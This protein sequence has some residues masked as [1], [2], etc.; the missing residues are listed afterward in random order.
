MKNEKIFEKAL[1]KS[2]EIGYNISVKQ[3][4][5]SPLSPVRIGGTGQ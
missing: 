3:S 1:D 4:R 2:G 5:A